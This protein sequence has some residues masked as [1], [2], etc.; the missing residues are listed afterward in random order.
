MCGIGGYSGSFA[1]SLLPRMNE[2]QAHRGPDAHDVWSDPIRGIGLAHRR[3]SIIDLSDA[4]R[5]PMWDADRRV[6]I[7][8]NGEIFNYRELRA[9]LVA[10]GA[11]FVAPATPR[12]CSSSTCGR[13]P[14]CS[15][16]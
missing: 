11:R 3:L 10:R 5:Q 6:V 1:P 14:P 9:E 8:F 7:T 4:G 2:L 13:G 12:S 15:R 16:A